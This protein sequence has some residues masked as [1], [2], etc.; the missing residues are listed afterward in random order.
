[1]ASFERITW[2]D[3]G[4]LR[5][6]CVGWE[7]VRNF[8]GLVYLLFVQ[9]VPTPQVNSGQDRARMGPELCIRTEIIRG[10]ELRIWI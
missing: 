5:R 7:F 3:A 1:V 9:E 6:R 4:N 8:G 10:P 2:L